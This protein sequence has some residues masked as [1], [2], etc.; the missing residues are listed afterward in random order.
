MTK[1]WMK[2]RGLDAKQLAELEIK[3]EQ[4]LFPG[5]LD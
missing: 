2:D 5:K 4:E 1:Q 3:V